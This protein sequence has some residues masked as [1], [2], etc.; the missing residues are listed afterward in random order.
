MTIEEMREL[1]TFC[2]TN[3]MGWSECRSGMQSKSDPTC[4]AWLLKTKRYCTRFKYGWR[5]TKDAVDAMDVLKK[6]AEKCQHELAINA[7]TPKLWGVGCIDWDTESTVKHEAE[8]LEL[9]ICLFAKQLFRKE[10][11]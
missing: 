7:P 4:D 2:A 9:A 3:V 10:T 6:C 11:K 5:P 8:T 1:D